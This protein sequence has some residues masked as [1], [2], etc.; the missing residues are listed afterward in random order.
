MRVFY[1]ASTLPVNIPGKSISSPVA[2]T[3]LIDMK[4]ITFQFPGL[5]ELAKFRLILQEASLEV[6]VHEL[7]ITC[8]YCSELMRE[9][10]VKLYGAVE[11]Q[12]RERV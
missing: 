2:A 9:E 6:N 10:A 3:N 4:A 5:T 12:L 11:L 8:N 7:T 1:K